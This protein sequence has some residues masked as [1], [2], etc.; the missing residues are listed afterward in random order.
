MDGMNNAQKCIVRYISYAY[1]GFLKRA[2]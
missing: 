1:I 2:N